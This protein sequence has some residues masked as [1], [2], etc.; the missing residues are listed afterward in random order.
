MVR[1]S[2]PLGRSPSGASA[3]PLRRTY[4]N[5]GGCQGSRGAARGRPRRSAGASRTVGFVQMVETVRR[6]VRRVAW[7]PAGARPGADRVTRR[8]ARSSGFTRPRDPG[9][10]TRRT[11]RRSRARC[12]GASAAGSRRG[13]PVPPGEP[14]PA[15]P[16]AAGP[17]QPERGLSRR[18]QPVPPSAAGPAERGRSR[19]ARW[20]GRARSA[21]STALDDAADERRTSGDGRRAPAQGPDRRARCARGAGHARG[22]QARRAGCGRAARGARARRAGCA[23]GGA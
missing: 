20:L 14:G 9:G 12:V 22:L 18:A 17:A 2:Y 4:R 21:G 1:A 3:G 10:S 23:R 19:R 15:R 7:A 11:G 6:V 16:S 5:G 13:W 8:P